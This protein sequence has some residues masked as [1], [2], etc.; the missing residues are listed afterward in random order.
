MLTLKAKNLKHIFSTSRYLQ[1][2]DEV[3]LPASSGM[4]VQWVIG[5]SQCLYRVFDLEGTPSARR[6]DALDILIR[7]WSPFDQ[8]GH[9]VVWEQSV[10][11]AWIWDASTTN[12]HLSN[13][14]IHALEVLP[15]S[16]FQPRQK[17]GVYGWESIDGG[18][19]YQL[20]KEEKLLAE[21]WFSSPPTPNNWLIFIRGLNLP[22]RLTTPL[23]LSTASVSETY[24]EITHTELLLRP[25][26][27][28]NQKFLPLLKEMQLEQWLVKGGAAFA[29]LIIVWQ[30]AAI[31][32]LLYAE[33]EVEQR[34]SSYSDEVS[35]VLE[36]RDEA[37]TKSRRANELLKL[38][39]F[40]SQAALMATLAPIVNKQKAEIK[41]WTYNLDKLEIV[42]EGERLQTL[43]LTKA[44]E[45]LSFIHTVTLD[46]ANKEN[47]HKFIMN[48]HVRK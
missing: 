40:P 15:E 48:L 1:L 14:G 35:S 19:C 47:Q 24:P 18:I 42:V 3:R 25:W 34:L 22:I 44:F 23:F 36:A 29:G 8:T 5:R 13:L 41:E 26:G 2:S 10:A 27:S 6:K 9:H 32:S 43:D 20:W 30:I 21:K 38:L 11:M 31:L 33:H 28:R 39:D 46:K 4:R 7:R 17:E 12:E 45:S 16:V 37:L